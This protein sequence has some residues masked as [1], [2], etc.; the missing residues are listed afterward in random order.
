MFQKTTCQ[1]KAYL[2]KHIAS[3]NPNINEKVI[4]IIPLIR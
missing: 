3:E 2:D 1:E 4:I